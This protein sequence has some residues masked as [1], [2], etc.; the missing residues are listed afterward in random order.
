MKPENTP[1]YGRL[2]AIGTQMVVMIGLGWYIGYK[3]DEYFEN[4]KPIYTLILGLLIMFGSIF[5]SVRQINKVF[6]S[7]S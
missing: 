4:E 6:D 2:L 7:N 1:Q 5:I 3:V